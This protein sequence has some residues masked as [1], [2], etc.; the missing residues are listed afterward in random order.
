M[1]NVFIFDSLLVI[2]FSIINFAVILDELDS[3][4]II[5]FENIFLCLIFGDYYLFEFLFK[6]SFLLHI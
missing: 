5:L 4:L 3:E 6:L 2:L 1:T